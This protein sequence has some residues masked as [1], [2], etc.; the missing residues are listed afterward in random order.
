MTRELSRRTLLK[1]AGVPA[2]SAAASS[3]TIP[4]PRF[5]S[6]DT[7]KIC[8]EAGLGGFGPSGAPGGGGYAAYAFNVG[9]TR[10]MM[11]AALSS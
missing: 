3:S 5:E 9:Y 7:P 11:Q 10:A 6:K 1:A 8:L 2:L 4:G